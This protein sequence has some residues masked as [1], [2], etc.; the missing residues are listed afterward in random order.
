MA[1]GQ[2][3]AST[4]S[5]AAPDA[6]I[7]GGRRLVKE[8]K[9]RGCHVIEGYGALHAPSLDWKGNR[10]MEGWLEQYIMR[11]YR[12]RP[13]VDS[14]MPDYTSSRAHRPLSAEEIGIIAS[15]LRLLAT[16]EVAI[17]EEPKE[18]FEESSCHSCHSKAYMKMW[19]PYKRTKIPGDVVRT[20]DSKPSLIMCLSCHILGELG[21]KTLRPSRQSSYRMAPDLI[22]SVKK[23]RLEWIIDYTRM[24]EHLK[25]KTGMPYLSLPDLVLNNI[26]NVLR[27]L[28]GRARSKGLDRLE[29]PEERYLMKE[30]SSLR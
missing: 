9:C 14:M 3:S 23:N 30:L 22:H 18:S 7:N 17:R 15:Y 16:S 4:T 27:I 28:K 24:K 10:Y 25:R 6:V 12:M 13:F 26:R 2:E 19:T 21:R 29:I 20:I 5:I 8:A 1:G 11:P